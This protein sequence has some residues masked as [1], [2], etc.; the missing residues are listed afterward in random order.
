[1]NEEI[2][3]TIEWSDKYQISNMGRLRSNKDKFTHKTA[4]WHII[5]GTVDHYGYRSIVLRD[6]GKIKMAKFHRLV[7][8]T[9]KPVKNS[10]NLFVDHINGNKLDNRLEN[11]RW[12]TPKENSNNLHETKPRYNAIQIKDNKGNTFN[13]Y[14]EASRYYGIPSNT[15]KNHANGNHKN[16]NTTHKKWKNIPPDLE[17]TIKDNKDFY[18]NNKYMEIG[19]KSLIEAIQKLQEVNLTIT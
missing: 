6:N 3:K 7:M 11:L 8:L 14:N 1:M 18:D 9:F 15:I 16:W 17:F 13:S 10:E 4:E 5:N 2:W 19:K 12:A